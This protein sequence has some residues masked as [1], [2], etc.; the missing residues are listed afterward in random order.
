MESGS[1]KPREA[2]KP[3]VKVEE[4]KVRAQ[5]K[6]EQAPEPPKVEDKPKNTENLILTA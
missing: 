4:P 2:V 3:E 1:V 6:Q 5:P